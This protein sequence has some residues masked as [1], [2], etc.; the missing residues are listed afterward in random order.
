MAL[1]RFYQRSYVFPSFFFTF[2]VVSVRNFN[3][4]QFVS[5]D[6]G[7]ILGH[8]CAFCKQLTGVDLRF[9]FSDI[10]LLQYSCVR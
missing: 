8:Y 7:H 1:Y 5:Y 4:Q 6:S 2:F 9:A 10:R 3:F